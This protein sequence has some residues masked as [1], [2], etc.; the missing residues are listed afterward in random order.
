MNTPNK[1]TVFRAVMVPVF[2]GIIGFL[3]TCGVVHPHDDD[4]L[5]ITRGAFPIFLYVKVHSPLLP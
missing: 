1:L 5:D 2:P 3:L 4:A